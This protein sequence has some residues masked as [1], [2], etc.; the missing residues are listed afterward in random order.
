MK[1]K[2]GTRGGVHRKKSPWECL[3]L[4]ISFQITAQFKE[5]SMGGCGIKCS[6]S[7]Y[8]VSVSIY[9]FEFNLSLLVA[10]NVADLER[11]FLTYSSISFV[12]FLSNILKIVSKS[13]PSIF[14]L[15]QL[16][17]MRR[18]SCYIGSCHVKEP[19]ILKLS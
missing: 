5:R 15:V 8:S 18:F 17:S 12:I 3:H 4:I 2:V 13:E 11:F 1:N 14:K 16:K 19:F 10:C 6:D 7:Y 9:L